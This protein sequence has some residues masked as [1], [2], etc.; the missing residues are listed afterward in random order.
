MIKLKELMGDT[1]STAGVL[2]NYA[3]EYL[4]LKRSSGK[5]S[6]PKGHI[7]EGE[8]PL[9]GAQRE[10]YEE[11]MITLSETP[12]LLFTTTN[13]EGGGYYIYGYQLTTR[14][15]PHLNEEHIGYGYF[16]KNNIPTHLDKGLRK[17]FNSYGI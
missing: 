6:I 4:L 3:G 10:L 11:T 8:S 2:M 16:N 15:I 5:F 12:K 13:K 7:K 1:T 9:E 17:L 14:V